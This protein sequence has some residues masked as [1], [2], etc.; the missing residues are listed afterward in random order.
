MMAHETRYAIHDQPSNVSMALNMWGLLE[1]TG[2]EQ[3]PVTVSCPRRVAWDRLAMFPAIRSR[4]WRARGL[5]AEQSHH[6]D[7]RIRFCTDQHGLIPICLS[8]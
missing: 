4:N 2:G 8:C 7:S 5:Y 3:P 6:V 1:Q